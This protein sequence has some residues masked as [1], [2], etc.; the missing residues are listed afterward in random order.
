[1]KVNFRV[2]RLTSLISFS[3][4][5]FWLALPVFAGVTGP[6]VAGQFYPADKN[7]L[8][9]AIDSYLKD[10]KVIEGEGQLLAIIAPHAGYEYSG[11][12]AGYAYKQLTNK[13]FDTV[14]ILGPSHYMQFDG[15]SIIPVG[16]YQTPLGK[17]KIDSEFAASLMSYS[18]KIGYVKEA[19]EKEHSVEVQIPFLQ[20]TLKNFKIVPIIFGYQSLENASI[21]SDA[22]VRAIGKKKVLIVASSDMSHYHTSEVASSMD[23]AAID[24]ISKGDINELMSKLAAGECE[25]CGY[26]PVIS[27]MMIADQLGANSYEILKYADTGDVTGDKSRVVGY[28]SAA[29]FRR[30]LVLDEFEKKRL[31]EIAR[32]TLESYLSTRVVPAFIVYEKELMQKTGVFVTLTKEG[33]LRGCVGYIKPVKPLYLAVSDMAIAAATEDTRFTPV[34]SEELSSLNIEISVLSPMTKISSFNEIVVGKHGLFIVNGGRSGLLLPQV[35][36][37]NHWNR[38][39]FLNNVCYKAS[40]DTAALN[41]PNTQLYIFTAD[42]FHEE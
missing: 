2:S 20:K 18:P 14:I 39:E 23:A 37:E 11:H 17:V 8:S 6:V 36:T 15:L 13:S 3:A 31:L 34:A 16:D 26:G 25:L 21:I 32:K 42:V 24:A 28:M 29:I 12:V 4:L 7:E 9:K 19:W 38:D 33:Q 22:I 30:P 40:L 1:M 35:A 10:Y 27:A 5:L 41:D